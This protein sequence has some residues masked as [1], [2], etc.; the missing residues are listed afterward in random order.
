MM[1]VVVVI[2]CDKDEI[3]IFFQWIVCLYFVC[4]VCDV[5]HDILF[6][7]IRVHASNCLGTVRQSNVLVP[8]GIEDV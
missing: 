5:F 2:L 7:G 6:Q 8:P 4:I 3:M 1:L